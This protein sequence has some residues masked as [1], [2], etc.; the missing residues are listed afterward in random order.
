MFSNFTAPASAQISR[1]ARRNLQVIALSL[2]KFH[3]RDKSQVTWSR[4]TQM[5]LAR[6]AQ[7]GVLPW[8]A[9]LA[10]PGQPG[11]GEDQYQ[12]CG[13]RD[14]DRRATPD[15]RACRHVRRDA[16]GAA[17]VAMGLAW[18]RFGAVKGAPPGAVSILPVGQGHG[19]KTIRIIRSGPMS[20]G[21]GSMLASVNWPYLRHTVTIEAAVMAGVVIADIGRRRLRTR[22][23]R[24]TE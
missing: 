22:R 11:K 10:W 24:A 16:R 3:D 20:L 18:N 4:A 7:V 6:H 1:V 21:L 17:V 8:R 12:A 15:D 9:D 2:V 13:Y 23:R 19:R 14:H 5:V